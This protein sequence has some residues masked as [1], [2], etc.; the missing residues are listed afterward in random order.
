MRRQMAQL[1]VGGLEALRAGGDHLLESLELV[2]HDAFVLPL[3][4]QSVCALHDLDGLE[5][6]FYHQQLVGVI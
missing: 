3:A 4:S 2:A 6:L 5:W 1:L